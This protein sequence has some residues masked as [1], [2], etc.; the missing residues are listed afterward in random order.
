M[1]IKPKSLSVY[2]TIFIYKRRE[3]TRKNE[4]ERERTRKNEKE[5]ERTRKKLHN[6]NGNVKHL[7]ALSII[8]I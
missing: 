6:K 5:R 1:D 3:R 7:F 8:V 2:K 4:K